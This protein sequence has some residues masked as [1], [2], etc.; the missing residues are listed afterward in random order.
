MVDILISIL[1]TVPAQ[2]ILPYSCYRL[3]KS[4]PTSRLITKGEEMDENATA[5]W[6]WQ[7]T[8]GEKSHDPLFLRDWLVRGGELG[9]DAGQYP[10]QEAGQGFAPLAGDHHHHILTGQLAG[11]CQTQT[12]A[13]HE[14]PFATLVFGDLRTLLGMED[15]LCDTAKQRH[16]EGL[17]GMGLW[18][19]EGR[20]KTL[21]L[22]A[23]QAVGSKALGNHTG[24][25]SCVSIFEP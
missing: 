25:T 8:E 14:L 5:P 19:R 13:W 18:W 16:K 10:K 21:Q 17:C 6:P 3:F 15:G 9:W 23:R 22:G 7:L 11:T 20:C 2:V 4:E 12:W 1:W 24:K